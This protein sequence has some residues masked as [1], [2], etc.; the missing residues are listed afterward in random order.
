MSWK[1]TRATRLLNIELP[2]VLGP[3]GGLSS[4]ELAATVSEAGGL[5]SYGLYGYDAE[6]IAATA[7]ELREATG[8]PFAL[9]LWLPIEGEE[10][11]TAGARQ[12]A[13]YV[14]ILRPYFELVG[15]EPPAQPDAYQ[16]DLQEQIQ[17]AIDARPAVL[18]FVFGVPS[19][20]VIEEAHRN[21]IV[22]AG[23]AT[24][25]D[26]AVALDAG[27]VDAIVATGMEAGGH[28]VSFLRAPED[29]LVGSMA[30]VPQV[31]DAVSVPV[32]AAGGISDGRGVA[33]ALALGAD[34]VQIGSAFLATRQSAISPAHLAAM[35]GP[36][37]AHT[38]LTRAL[39]GRLARGIP[40]RIIAE[41]A[42]PAAHAPFPIQ[43]WLTGKFRP[44]AA[45]QGIPDLMSLWAGQST[46]LIREDDARKLV[47]NIVESVDATVGRLGQT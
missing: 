45:A 29:S 9:N 17:A 38:V 44:A 10:P 41:L 46:P 31:V 25:V 28:R 7:R 39:S 12:F 4:V 18:S 15:V 22:V 33:A 13:A 3:F 27:G 43:N 30:L 2:I 11:P 35:R 42:D 16:P 5:G 32:I 40:N 23:T 24:T 8:K 1:D 47:A 34:A 37:A 20:A 14:D 21:G 6:R 19:G 26:E 36:D